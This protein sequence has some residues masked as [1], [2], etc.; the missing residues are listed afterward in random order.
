MAL[1]QVLLFGL[2]TWLV[3]TDSAA[4]HS[5]VLS[6]ALFPGYVTCVLLGVLVK[7]AEQENPTEQK[8]QNEGYKMWRVEFLVAR[9]SLLVLALFVLL[10]VGLAKRNFTAAIDLVCYALGNCGLTILFTRPWLAAWNVARN[11]GVRVDA[12]RPEQHLPPT[13]SSTQL[14]DSPG[15]VLTASIYSE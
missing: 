15:S 13:N 2:G 6:A 8:G 3:K 14:A 4:R 12:F 10:G 11:F 9:A 1:S 5:L 7:V